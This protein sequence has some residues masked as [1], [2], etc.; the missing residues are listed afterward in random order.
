MAVELMGEMEYSIHPPSSFIQQSWPA[1]LPG[2]R[3]P[4]LSVLVLLQR[5]PIALCRSTLEVKAAKNALRDRSFQLLLPLVE[6]LRTHHYQATMFDPCTGLPYRSQLSG[7]PLNDVAVVHA[8]LGYERQQYG[9]CYCILHPNWGSSVYP[10]IMLS[11]ALPT[12]LERLGLAH[13]YVNN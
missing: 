3:M 6:R 7:L 10:T 8:V 5:S 12:T 9:Q 1:L 2:W 4:V 11:S 13:H